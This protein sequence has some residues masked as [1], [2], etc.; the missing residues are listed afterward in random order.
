MLDP[1]RQEVV[2]QARTVVV[3]VGTNVLAAADGRLDPLRLQSLADQI[4]RLRQTGRQIALVSSGAIGAGIGRLELGKRPTDLRHLQ[5]CAAIGQSFLM[6]AYQECLDQH[7]VNTAQILVTAGDFD[8]RVRYLNVRNTI[9]TL[10]EWGVLPII[11]ENDT[12]SVAEIKFGD[13]DHLAAMVTN[14]LRAP[15][16]I[17]LTVVDGLFAGDPRTDPAPRKLD[18]VPLIDGAVMDLAGGSKSALGIGGMRSKL[19]AARLAT[20]AGESVIIANGAVTGILDAIFAAEPVGTLFL[21][22]GSSVPAWK[23]WLGYTA[24]PKGRLLIDAGAHAAVTKKGR[25]LLPIGVVQVQGHFSKGDVVAL[26]DPAGLEFGRGLTN[27]S[28]A[29]AQRIVG[30]R[31][32]Q[33]GEVIGS[34]PYEEIV[35][36]DNLV[37]IE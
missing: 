16:L 18:T 29:D 34:V 28:A 31:T 3:K 25:S 11:N 21:P 24:S 12:V 22:H 8:N 17:L 36:R 13:N 19:R 2:T 1:V 33:I 15:L 20:A 5:A 4:Q 26:C 7:A 35:H 27:Y 9:L 23:R 14:L 10:F 37:V 6:R 30:L 32:E